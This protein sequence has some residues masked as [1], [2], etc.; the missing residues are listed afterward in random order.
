MSHH[1]ITL[2]PHHPSPLSPVQVNCLEPH[3]HIPVLA[4]SGLDHDVKIFTPTADKPSTLEGLTDVCC[5][6]VGCVCVC[7][8]KEGGGGLPIVPQNVCRKSVPCVALLWYPQCLALLPPHFIT[9]S[10]HHSITNPFS[11]FVTTQQLSLISDL[12]EKWKEV[13]CS[14]Q[15]LFHTES[16]WGGGGGGGGNW[17]TFFMTF[18]DTVTHIHPCAS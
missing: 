3:P 7:V 8:G 5:V 12:S 13:W 6:R 4:T 17:S 18:K 2:S 11:Q 9:P 10:L 16:G 14:E 1:L 15:H